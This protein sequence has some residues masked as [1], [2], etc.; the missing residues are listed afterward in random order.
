MADVET[1]AAESSPAASNTPSPQ[2]EQSQDFSIPKDPAAYAEWRNTGKL[3]GDPKP[4]KDESA[5]S[6]SSADDESG[7]AAPAS[8]AGKGKRQERTNADTR[9][10]ELN[11][12]IRELLAMREQL[13]QDVA[14]GKK[15]VKAESSTAPEAHAPEALKRPVKPKQDEFDSWDAFEAAQ[16]K[17]LEDLADF[18]AA[19]RIEEHTQRQR[20]EAT[21]REMQQRLDAA[22]ERYGEEAE[23]KITETAKTIFSDAGV[24]PA[25]KTALGRSEVLVDALYVMGSDAKEFSAFL[26]LAKKD[27]LEALRKWFTVEGLVKEELSGKAAPKAESAGAPPRGPDGKF[28]PEKPV[29]KSAP[30][31]PVELNGNASPPG[32]ESERAAHS[33]DFRAFKHDRDRKD[34]LRYRGQ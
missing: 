6:K 29:K 20:Q 9:K 19:A 24:P 13:R 31:P 14:P 26:D 12:E 21:Q 28:L 27:P 18:K 33:G 32:D 4:S 23:P 8:E 10:E 16:D 7:K 22:R 25:I 5:P 34:L 11:R 1:P 2:T 3:P 15:D 30:A 17:Y